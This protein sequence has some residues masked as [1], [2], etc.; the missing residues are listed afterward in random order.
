VR[1][2]KD[3]SS[4]RRKVGLVIAAENIIKDVNALRQSKRN[5]ITSR[6]GE[7]ATSQI[8]SRILTDTFGVAADGLKKQRKL[9]RREYAAGV[10]WAQIEPRWMLLALNKASIKRFVTPKGE[11]F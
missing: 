4:T 5:G 1:Q 2:I 6:K 10:K 8:L 11:W 9:L 7:V 3:T